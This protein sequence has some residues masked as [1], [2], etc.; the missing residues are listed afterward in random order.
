[1]QAS[2][3]RSVLVVEDDA[4]TAAFLADNLRA[5]GFQVAGA[6]AAAEA[7]RAIEL[8]QPDIV[9]LDLGLESGS[10][11]EVLD[12]VR[13]SDSASSRIDPDLPV[14]VLTG[15]GAEV[16][17]VRGFA[18]GAD[19]YVCKPFSYAELVARLGAVLRRA[20]GR[21]QRG[22]IRV[23]ELT[24]DPQT[25]VVRLGGEQ[26]ALSA[27]EFALL[28]AL[29]VEPTRVLS[30]AELLRDVWGYASIG[31]TRTVDA[32]ASR[33]RKKL[34]GTGRFIHNVRGVGYRL[35]DTP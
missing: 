21:R 4:A 22:S 11:L 2:E 9:L 24:V 17:R 33:L 23:G 28:L 29:A 27:K 34:G 35:L 30:K 18:R 32:H 16:D 1:M 10:G 15:R 6:A 19:D 5:D 20:S 14:I 8:R 13:A 26:V 7:V 31:A 3:N 12:R 25:R